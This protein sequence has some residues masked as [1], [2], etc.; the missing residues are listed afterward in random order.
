MRI[1]RSVISKYTFIDILDEMFRVIKLKV[2][3]RD[4]VG[5]GVAMVSKNPVGTSIKRTLLWQTG[6]RKVAKEFR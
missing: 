6:Q 4:M 1:F 3:G 5:G 2:T